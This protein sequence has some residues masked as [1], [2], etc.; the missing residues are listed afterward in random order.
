MANF[1]HMK[2]PEEQ[3]EL[4]RSE[5]MAN[6]GGI[7]FEKVKDPQT[8][9]EHSFV[10]VFGVSVESYAT[11]E[12]IEKIKQEVVLSDVDKK[13]L[14]A[15]AEAY[16]LKQAFFLEG[17]PGAGKTFLEE[18]FIQMIHGAKTPILRIYGTP[19]TTETDIL[20]KWAPRV[21][22]NNK[23][24]FDEE[25]GKIM[26]TG[27]G[28]LERE[29]WNAEMAETK[30]N[31]SDGKISQDEYEIQ[32]Q[33]R[34][35]EHL[36]RTREI[37]LS[38]SILKKLVEQENEW[39]FEKGPLLLAYDGNNGDGAPLIVDEFNLIPSNYQQIFLSIGGKSGGLSD[40]ISY[41]GGSGDP[42][43]KRGK[44][45]WICGASNFPEKTQGRGEV[46]PP[47]TDRVVWMTVSSEES[48]K[49]KDAI[50]ETAGGRLTHRAD[51]LKKETIK[52][53]PIVE[54][55]IA[56][57]KVL[58]EKLGELLA[59]V[60]K[61]LDTNFCNYYE[62][63]GDSLSVGG[64]KIR[65]HQ[66]MEFSPRNMMRVFSY[67]DTMQVRDKESGSIDFTATLKS[68]Y[69][70]YY[71]AR[72]A[73]E[74]EREKAR[75]LFTT[76]MEGVIG[77]DKNGVKVAE[78]LKQLVESATPEGEERRKQQEEEN[79]KL[80]E[81]QAKRDAEDAM[82][83]LKKDTNIPDNIKEMLKGIS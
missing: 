22:E 20:G 81:R 59:D 49:K 53:S 72:L 7:F 82:E 35:A 77:W 25:Y 6:E 26:E 73:G 45:A 10:N 64:E 23:V 79:K 65:R 43:H 83:E 29:K 11:E 37:L 60:V 15:E 39:E 8:G 74:E 70:L 27:G 40:N 67:L 21:D 54:N 62:T 69:E 12:E 66:K 61:L 55:G 48:Q 38:S 19:R 80:K 13:I 51:K 18:V 75:K 4:D 41:W 68:A 56:W 31:L 17:D 33:I 14:R 5:R 71:V 24:A 52:F 47:M 57:D 32:I 76:V 28:A 1:F 2:S 42:Q 3:R 46:V 58:G 9:E 63:V 50:A 78:R 34:L 44:N 16:N 36:N 30:A